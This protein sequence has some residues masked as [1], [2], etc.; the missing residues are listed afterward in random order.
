MDDG[1]TVIVLTNLGSW[2]DDTP[3]AYTW[4]TNEN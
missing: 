2:G 1:L 4:R 3:D